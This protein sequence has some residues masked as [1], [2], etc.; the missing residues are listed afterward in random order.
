MGG[1]SGGGNGTFGCAMENM[2]SEVG[3]SVWSSTGDA[4]NRWVEGDQ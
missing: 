2:A 4:T 1:G 3:L